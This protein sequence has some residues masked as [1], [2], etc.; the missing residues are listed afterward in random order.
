MG[1]PKGNK[2]AQGI[3]T[4]GRPPKYDDPLELYEKINDYFESCKPVENVDEESGERYMSYPDHIT[5][6]GLCLYCGFE[7]RQ[8]F[9][10]YEEK[11]E[12][13]YIIKRARLVI[14]NAYEI[15][16]QYK[17]PT[18]YIFALKNMGWFDKTEVEHSGGVTLNFDHEDADL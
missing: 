13:S 12:F 7:S 4:S 6:T 17:S 10:A 11:K 15:G 3:E 2:F 9:Y 1:A 14:E 5:I 16:L 8:S 18:G